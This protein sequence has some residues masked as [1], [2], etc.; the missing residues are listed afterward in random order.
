MAAIGTGL[1]LSILSGC[2]K[3]EAP[4]V[5][6]TVQAEKPEQGAIAEKITADAVLTP[7]A[8]AAIEPKI[9]APVKKFLV[10]RGAKVKEGELLAVLENADLTAAALDNKGAYQAAQAAYATATRAQVPEDVQKAE[11]DYAQA[12][13]NLDLN[14]SIVNSRKQLFAEGAIPGRDLDTAQAAL[15]QAQAAFDTA[16]KHLESMQKV[17]RDAELK[18]AEG[19][20]TSAEGKMKGADAQVSYSEI[21]SPINGVVTDR[22][23]FAG[24]TAA[25]G[26][27][28]ITV[29]DTSV[30]IAK[31]HLAQTLAQQMKVG[32]TAQLQVPG[33]ADPVDAKVSL[34]SPALDPGSTTLE[35][36]IKADNKKGE[37]K[38]GTPVK[39]IITGRSV[40]KAWKIPQTAVLTAQDGSK[41]V[42]VIG[43][44]GAAHKKAVTL[45]ISNG[46]DVQVLNGIAPG[47]TVIT[48]GAYGLDEGT[49]VKAGK[50]DADDAAKPDAKGGDKD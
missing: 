32:D 29:M 20:L 41:S 2:K 44:D 45:G 30:V 43:A 10:Q 18:S 36:W 14:Q 40:E 7:Q 25:A 48:G 34:I 16:N 27:P 50:A 3:E 19:Q 26:A 4:A 15:V 23:L 35:V 11:L 12:K 6:V 5:E 38:V 46:E 47:D 42:M 22:P 8:Q 31:T 9:T 49:K 24:E 28:L 13:A 39:I 17:S 33:I 37:L 1:A 21:R